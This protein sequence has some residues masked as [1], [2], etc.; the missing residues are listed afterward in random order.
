V[1]GAF[2]YATGSNGHEFLTKTLSLRDSKSVVIWS[3]SADDRDVPKNASSATD[4]TGSKPL[5]PRGRGSVEMADD[6]RLRDL[7]AVNMRILRNRR[8]LSQE[9]L[10]DLCDLDRTYVSSVERKKRNLSIANVQRITDAL[11]VDV[12][13]LFTPELE[14]L[15]QLDA[16]M[17]K[18]L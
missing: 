3:S 10:A 16:L 2:A 7:F 6:Y 5:S 12:R 1:P 9:D 13:L 8:G 11:G 14:Q 17:S 18:G 15:P 4:S